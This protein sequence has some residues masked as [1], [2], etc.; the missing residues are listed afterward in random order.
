MEFKTCTICGEVKLIKDF[1]FSYVNNR[2]IAQ[3][4][5]CMNRYGKKRR[6]KNSTNIN[7]KQSEAQKRRFADVTNHPSYGKKIPKETREKMRIAHLG[8]KIGPWTTEHKTKISESKKGKSL[9]LSEAQH[10]N[11]SEKRKGNKNPNWKG[12][13]SF[14]PHTP[15]FNEQLKELIR[16]RD[17]FQCQLCGCSEIENNQKLDVHHADYNK[18]NC[19][20]LN[21]ISL[22]HRCN[23]IVNYGRNKWKRFFDRKINKKMN[24]NKIQLSFR[25]NKKEQSNFYH[26]I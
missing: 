14:L 4:K 26:R 9:N 24:S 15:E 25:F 11:R 16:H 6:E 21:L 13:I 22:C 20:P 3:C 8:K 19:N 2:H 5:I 7:K 12:G 18:V 23:V 10:K 17:G 1:H